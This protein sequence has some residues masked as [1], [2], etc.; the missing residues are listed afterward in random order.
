MMFCFVF[1]EYSSGE[2]KA[3]N[4]YQTTHRDKCSRHGKDK[5]Q[6]AGEIKMVGE[7]S[8]SFTKDVTF[9]LVFKV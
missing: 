5:V 6:S 8:H 7:L 4:N 3:T 9:N 2:D 1:E